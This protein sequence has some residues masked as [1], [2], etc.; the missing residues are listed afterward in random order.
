LDAKLRVQMRAEIAALQRELAVTTVYVTHD[1]IEAMTMGDRVAVL[2][3]GYLQQVDTPQNLYDHPTNIFVAG[4]GGA[5]GS[6]DAGKTFHPC[7]P[8]GGEVTALRGGPGGQEFAGNDNDWTGWHTSDLFQ[9]STAKQ[10]QAGIS[11]GLTKKVG[12]H[13]YAVKA[14]DITMDGKSIADDVFRGGCVNPK[15]VTA[16]PDGHVLVGQYGGSL[17]LGTP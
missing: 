3:D 6:N 11:G 17:L 4:R 2:K 7:A 14:G 10:N 15:A 1:Q 12:S 9:H 16:S 8:D 5:W 13:T